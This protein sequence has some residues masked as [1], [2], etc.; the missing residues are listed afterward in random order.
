MRPKLMRPKLIA[1]LAAIAGTASADVIQINFSGNAAIVVNGDDHL[2]N[3]VNTGDSFSGFVKYDTDT[4]VTSFSE[5]PNGGPVFGETF[6]PA[7][8]G[9][10]FDLSVTIDGI[11]FQSSANY[12][13]VISTNT[14]GNL[15]DQVGFNLKETQPGVPSGLT[16]PD[17][18]GSSFIDIALNPESFVALPTSVT[19]DEF[20]IKHLAIQYASLGNPNLDDLTI[21]GNI[22]SLSSTDLGSAAPEPSTFVLIGGALALLGAV[23]RRTFAAR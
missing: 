18:N 7:S 8:G 2:N 4:P 3:A 14:T 20:T 15:S 17:F 19:A 23:R 10:I 5:G 6:S 11:A 21:D 12:A 1:L 9:N 13:G 22:T 16:D